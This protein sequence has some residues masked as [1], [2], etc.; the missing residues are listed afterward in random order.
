LSISTISRRYAKALINLG[1]EQNMVKRYG[2]ELAEISSVFAAE[3]FLR[4]ILESPTLS[5]EKKS[6]ILSELMGLLEISDGMKNFLGHLL[7]KGRLS[8]L[9]GI[10]GNYRELADELSGILRARITSPTELNKN[11]Q[12]AV[13]A[14]LEKQTGKKI[15]LKVRLDRSLIGGIQAEI[16]GRVFDGSVKTQL[17]RIEDTLKKG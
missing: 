5:L 10:E 6:A 7:L 4:L 11:Q 14:G 13:K 16:G 1:A 8:H 17:K 2:D 15:E 3:D 9:A 12:D